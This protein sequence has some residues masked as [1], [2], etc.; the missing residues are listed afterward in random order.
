MKISFAPDVVKESEAQ[1]LNAGFTTTTDLRSLLDR[2]TAQAD[3]SWRYNNGSV[4]I[5][6]FE[7]K[8]FKIAALPGDT[9]TTTTVS[10]RNSV[11]AGSAASSSSSGQDS[12]STL[13]LQF[14]DGL[15]NDLKSLVAQNSTY[16]VSESNS[17]I[18]IT[19]TPQVLGV[20]ESYVKNL[21]ALRMRQIVLEVH[22]YK[23]D[24]QSG[25]DFGLA[26]KGAIAS[27]LGNNLQGSLTTPSTTSISTGLMT[28]M[29][30]GGAAGSPSAIIS[31]LSSMGQ[32]SVAAESSQMVLSGEN[33]SINSLR[34]ITYL[35][36]VSSTPNANNTTST[37]LKPAT[38]TEGFAM[39]LTPTLAG[40]YVLIGGSIDLSTLDSL[41]TQSSGGQSITT[42]N[43]T[44]G[45]Q[46]VRVGVR[47]GETY[48]YALRQ[49]NTNTSDS[50]TLG[51]SSFL[52]P[53]GGQHA[54]K[55]SRKTLVIT[56]TPYIV[57]PKTN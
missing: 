50:G 15:K 29:T 42:P 55:E 18:T 56:I 20:V 48:V 16:S 19:A 27:N 34:E 23:V 37:S 28:I 38:V 45:S 13:K 31:A 46:L 25:R 43:R 8:V 40:D 47:S 1:I 30:L 35:A 52:T 41:E 53:F 9:V 14:W 36:E 39:T 2:V 22:A 5:F 44:S 54:S 32:T 10:N 24:L 12:K 7:T 4:E 17:T 3:M 6:R 21:N 57:N 11:G 33:A 51:T 26:F 49:N